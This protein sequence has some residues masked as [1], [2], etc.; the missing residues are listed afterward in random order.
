MIESINAYIN[1]SLGV[2]IL[3]NK[4]T[5]KI[6]IL[7][8]GRGYLLPV[9]SR[10]AFR[11]GLDLYPAQGHMARLGKVV[12]SAL[13]GVG[14]KGPG[15]SQFRLE[16]GEGSVFQ[17]LRK[18]FN[19][20][21]LCFAV[22]LGTPGPHRK[23]VVQVMT[24]EGEV[25]GY[26]KIGWNKATKELVVNEAQMHNKIRCLN[27]P[28]L[29]IPDVVHL[30]Q[31]GCSTIL[32]TRP[33]E[34]VNG[35]K[36]DN[37]SFQ[38]LVEIL[39]KLA[40]QTRED[41]TFLEVPFWQELNDRLL[42]LSDYLPHYQLEILTHALKIFEN[43]LRDVELPWV[44][45]LGDVTRWNTA[46]DEQ[47]GLLQVIDLEYAKE[48]WLVGWDLFRFFDR[49]SVIPTSK[50]FGYYRA[51]G[52]DPE[53]MDTLQLAFWVDLFTEW[54]LTWKNAELLISP[55]ARN[56]FRKIAGIIHFLNTQLEVR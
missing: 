49:F 55:A 17:T 12:L 35:G 47:S 6:L 31:E 41:R 27:F 10:C 38:E 46:I 40:N 15:L 54:A 52:V 44:L 5:H 24:R 34:G 37:E 14:L 45:R 23:P 26:A 1:Q 21:D 7:P 11:K 48:H 16:N 9:G 28:H 53:Q 51:V 25:L 50:L 36:W 3:F 29:R 20:D 43:R 18:A 22:S 42:H 32:I 39:A 30:S 4:A 8:D 19:R 13:A 56:V 2:Q 33:L